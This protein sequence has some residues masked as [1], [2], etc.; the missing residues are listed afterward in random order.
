M[1][2]AP[3]ASEAANDGDFI[4]AVSAAITCVTGNSNFKIKSIKKG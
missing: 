1:A 2:D 4:A 3:D